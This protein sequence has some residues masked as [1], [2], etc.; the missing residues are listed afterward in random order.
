MRKR[1][2][3]LDVRTKDG[4][5]SMFTCPHC[6]GT[7]SGVVDS[8]SYADNVRR[9]KR[10]CVLCRGRFTTYEVIDEMYQII[11]GLIDGLSWVGQ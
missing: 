4:G 10:V 6:D 5:N 7:S 3:R 2:E 1:T 11:V 8:R 9:R